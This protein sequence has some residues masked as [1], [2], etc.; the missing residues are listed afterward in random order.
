MKYVIFNADDWGAST[1]VNKGIL[2]CH[3]KGVLTSASLMVTGRA[4]AEAVRLSEENPKLAVGLHFDVW[5]EDERS[6]DVDNLSA[7]R[8]EFRRQLDE[9]HHLTGKFPTHVDSHRHMHRTERLMPLF[10]ELVEPLKVP[11]R[12]DGRVHFIGGFY[13]QWEWQVT[14]LEYVS[15]PFLTRMLKEEVQSD[16]TEI[17][18]HPGYRSPD[19]QAVYLIEREE[20]VR[21]LTNPAIRRAITEFDITL[22]SYLDYKA[23]SIRIR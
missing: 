5:G 4:V 1:G 7:V 19:Y 21:T 15:V 14:N 2:E 9:F 22:A 12:G 3:Q 17:S 6:F 18:C 13:A 8:D 10:S 16:W 20:E 11:L 23:D